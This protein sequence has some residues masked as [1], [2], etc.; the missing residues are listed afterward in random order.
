MGVIKTMTPS[1]DFE[2]VME[3]LTPFTQSQNRLFIFCV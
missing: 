2:G 1:L 3:T